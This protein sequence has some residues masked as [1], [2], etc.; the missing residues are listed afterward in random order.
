M[1]MRGGEASPEVGMFRPPLNL[2]AP[3]PTTVQDMALRLTVPTEAPAQQQDAAASR[4][5]TPA[6]AAAPTV[7]PATALA[8]R[9]HALL[10]ARRFDAYRALFDETAAIADPHRRFQA[11]RALVEAGLSTSASNPAHVAPLFAAIAASTIALLE[12]E[13]REPTLLNHAGIAFYEL[14]AIVPAEKLFGAARR[15]D[16]TLPHVQ[17]NLDECARRRRAGLAEPRGLPAA[18][19]A[20]L[21]TLVPRAKRVA[22]AARPATGLTLS[23]CM[24]VRDEEAMLGRCLAAVQD[25]VDEIIVVDTGST[26]RTV[27][28]ATEHGARV[29]HH[30]WTGDFAAARNVSFAAATGDWVMYLDADEVLHEEDA[31]RLKAL[32]GRTWREAF[33]LVE[34]NHTGDLGDGTAVTHSALRVFRNRPE[35]R[36]EGRIHEQ[37]AQHLPAYLP[38]RLEHTDVRVEH[39][40]YLGAVRD[41]KGKSQRN[42]ELLERQLAEGGD[43]PFLHFNLGSEHAAAGDAERALDEFRTAWTMLRTDA[44]LTSYGFAPSLASRLVKALRVCNR[45]DEGET[46]AAE[47][48]ELFPGFTDIVFE[49]ALIARARGD[50]ATAA[51]LLHRCLEMGDA[52]ASYSATVGCGTY[53]A[54]VS[55]AEIA[56]AA[57]DHETAAELLR[58]TLA[59]HPTFIGTVELLADTL[60]RRGVAAADVVA[61]IHA[62]VE[63]LTPTVR[64][65]LAV[66]LYEHGAVAEAEAELRGVLA[67]QPSAAPARVALAEALLS[68]GR[69]DDAAAEAALVDDDAPVK[70]AALR[71]E[72]FA[73][74]AAGETPEIDAD[75]APARTHLDA[76]E[77]GLFTAWATDGGVPAAAAP[78]AATM[79]DALAR[80]ERFDAFERLAEALDRGTT[81]WRETRELLAGVYLRRGFLT[82]AADEWIAVVQRTGADRPAL[83]GL[84]EVARRQGLD[85]DAALLAAEA[86]TLA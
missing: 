38:E 18:V 42:I 2:T 67:A 57:G 31:E 71:T 80:L 79:L 84:A 54:R 81:P 63:Q 36:F 30:T 11:R 14:G 82:S 86:R 3:P 45:L 64:F 61:E 1:D 6:A 41:A 37:I 21:R 16:P 15:L 39:F 50:H 70:P 32:T 72:L 13:P 26:D 23:L 52:P 74:L 69:L 75:G 78:L 46:T 9:A 7:V 19:L 68:Q 29:L 77:R 24:I 43:T 12:D 28:I 33:Y 40:G 20:E 51:A 25:A 5:A 76:A 44:R 56:R 58:E 49:Q 4:P 55:L 53:L 65:L 62:G 27:E 73:R 83:E 34:T 85:D 10:A 48:L 66:P 22:A 17:G 59:C 47:I 8:A 35:Y 60:L